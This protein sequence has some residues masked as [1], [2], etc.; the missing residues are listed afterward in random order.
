MRKIL[1][2][3][4]YA[5]KKINWA[6]ILF[7]TVT[8]VGGLGVMP[9]Y[10]HR[11]G[12][13]LS[14]WILFAVYFVCSGLSITAG[15]HRLYAHRTYQARP[16]LQLF[17][18][19][20]GAS[21]FEQ[22]A[23]KWSSQHRNHHLYLDTERDPYSITKGFWHAHMGWLVGWDRTKNFE[24]VA[25]LRQNALIVHQHAHFKLWA[26]GAGI[27]TPVL[28]GALAGHALGAFLI[29]V[30][31][32]IVFV[33]QMTFCINSFCHLIGTAN[34]DPSTSARDHWFIA[35][36]TF[37]EG[38]HNFHHRFPSDYRNGIR[39]YHW[40]PSKWA[41]SLFRRAG[42]AYNLRKAPYFHILHARLASQNR[43]V[44][45]RL[46][47]KLSRHPD[48][49]RFNRAFER[50]YQKLQ[51]AFSSFQSAATEYQRLV[52]AKVASRASVEGIKK[53]AL[54]NLRARKEAFRSTYQKWVRYI[55]ARLAVEALPLQADKRGIS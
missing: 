27:V 30:C 1:P 13:V 17:L 51:R 53:T 44:R 12:F 11:N 34:Y 38:Y 33:Q 2:D 21:A 5:F 40:D 42:Q 25:D 55:E 24:N 52:R 14:D 43:Q 3:P 32:R 10:L 16:L 23:L 18:L 29:G 35:L 50:H 54:E 49:I 20:F 19:F 15:Y 41:I 48:F 26:I 7:F 6:N 9:F 28:I 4:D 31:F 37:G 46:A 47:Q 45:L 8:G 22:S 36:L 39:W